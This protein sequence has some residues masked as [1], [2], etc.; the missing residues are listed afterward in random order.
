MFW[1]TGEWH[2]EPGREDEFMAAWVDLVAWS[3]GAFPG[4][5]ALL[6]RSREE[7]GV[8]L[9]VASWPNDDQWAGWRE[10]PGV[11]ERIDALLRLAS[12]HQRR[13]FDQVMEQS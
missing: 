3:K 8:F 13:T 1:A 9:S 10:V 7:P 12:W 6:L 11:E 4:R 2:I 5:Q